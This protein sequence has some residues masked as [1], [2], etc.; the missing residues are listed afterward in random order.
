MTHLLFAEGKFLEVISVNF[1]QMIISILNLV[2]LYLI[3]KKFLFKPVKK[4][5]ADRRA[6]VDDLYGSAEAA[7]SEAE[8]ARDEYTAKLGNAD[9][10]ARQIV[11]DATKRANERADEIV[12]GAKEEAERLRHR[13]DEEI[14]QERKKAL[15]EVKN[16]ISDISV[17]I[18]EK[19]VGREIREEDHREMI[20]QFIRDLED[21]D[22]V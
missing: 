6:Q 12:G 3:L 20:D 9:E 18:A 7:K 17:E 22:R 5:L 21:G 1:W 19:V 15:N 2:I 4:T 10:S 8:T 14:A 13:A 11:S 16:E